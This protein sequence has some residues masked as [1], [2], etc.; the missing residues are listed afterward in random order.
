MVIHPA[1]TELHKL[2]D[3][4]IAGGATL[5]D[6]LP[7]LLHLRACPPQYNTDTPG[8]D[9]YPLLF[10]SGERP[11]IQLIEHHER[12]LEYIYPNVRTLPETP[13]VQDLTHDFGSHADR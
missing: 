13:L 8:D 10:Y 4:Y 11:A 12:R 3:R 6:L 2:I 1:V 7:R 9:D 5:D